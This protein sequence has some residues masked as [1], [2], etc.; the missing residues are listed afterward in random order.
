MPPAHEADDVI[1]ADLQAD[2]DRNHGI[3]D[4][5]QE[6]QQQCRKRAEQAVR[7]PR[8]RD[9]HD[10]DQRALDAAEN[11]QRQRGQGQQVT[12][13]GEQEQC[14]ES[15]AVA[16]A[17]RAHVGPEDAQHPRHPEILQ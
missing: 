1:I 14:E 11:E 13:C 4:K 9:E 3:G 8:Q 2:A 6:R 12:S 5:A 10:Q 16:E 17:D 7:R 15:D